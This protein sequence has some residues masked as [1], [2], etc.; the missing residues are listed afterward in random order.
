MK[1]T[2][3]PY[4]PQYTTTPPITTTTPPSSPSQ[5]NQSQPPGLNPYFEELGITTD[6]TLTPAVYNLWQSFASIFLPQS[7][8]LPPS[9]NPVSLLPYAHIVDQLRPFDLILIRTPGFFYT[10]MRRVVEHS[11]DHVAIVL[12]QSCALHI[13]PPFTRIIPVATLLSPIRKPIILRPKLHP[14]LPSQSPSIPSPTI[15]I[16]SKVVSP[17][18]WGP[19]S[20]SM[21]DNGTHNVAISS[22]HIMDIYSKIITHP[23]LLTSLKPP[24]IFSPQVDI[25]S[26]PNYPILKNN[27]IQQFLLF[28]ELFSLLGTHYDSLKMY[29]LWGKLALNRVT[30]QPL[31]K[32]D[33]SG[34]ICTDA[35]INILLHYDFLHLQNVAKNWSLLNSHT[36]YKFNKRSN[37]A[38][39][40][41]KQ[42]ILPHN[43]KYDNL[44]RSTKPHTTAP[45]SPTPSL[46]QSLHPSIHLQI[47]PQPS[48]LHELPLS[49]LEALDY[50][51]ISAWSLNDLLQ[52]THDHIIEPNPQ[53][54]QKFSNIPHL[55]MGM[56]KD[57]QRVGLGFGKNGT[58]LDEQKSG[59]FPQ[60]FSA[61]ENQQLFEGLLTDIDT[62]P[63]QITNPDR[64]LMSTNQGTPSAQQNPSH[65]QTTTSSSLNPTIYQPTSAVPPTHPLDL[66]SVLQHSKNFNTLVNT[67]LLIDSAFEVIKPPEPIPIELI[68][69]FCNQL[70][71]LCANFV[72]RETTDKKNGLGIKSEG[73]GERIELEKSHLRS[74]PQNTPNDEQTKV[75]LNREALLQL[76]NPYFRPIPPKQSQLTPK[77]NPPS[78]ISPSSPS[79]PIEFPNQNLSST[80]EEDITVILADSL[81]YHLLSKLPGMIPFFILQALKRGLESLQRGKKYDIKM[82]VFLTS[83]KIS[84][85]ILAKLESE[86]KLMYNELVLGP[87]VET[88]KILKGKAG[89]V[90]H[91]D[92]Y[93]NQTNEIGESIPANFSLTPLPH[94]GG[95]TL[96]QQQA[97]GTKTTP[98]ENP[99]PHNPNIAQRLQNLFLNLT[100][101]AQN[102]LFKKEN[103]SENNPDGLDPS[104]Q[105]RL[106]EFN[107]EHDPKQAIVI[108]KESD[109]KNLAKNNRI[110]QFPTWMEAILPL[111]LVV[112]IKELVNI[113]ISPLDG[114]KAHK[115]SQGGIKGS[116]NTNPHPF[117]SIKYLSSIPAPFLLYIWSLLKP[118]VRFYLLLTILSKFLPYLIY[119]LTATMLMTIASLPT[120]TISWLSSRA[121]GVTPPPNIIDVNFLALHPEHGQNILHKNSTSLLSKLSILKPSRISPQSK[122]AIIFRPNL[123]GNFKTRFITFVSAV[124][125]ASVLRYV[126]NSR[127][128]HQA[129]Q[130]KVSGDNTQTHKKSFLSKALALQEGS[131]ERLQPRVINRVFGPFGD[132]NGVIK[133]RLPQQRTI[134]P[135]QVDETELLS[136]TPSRIIQQIQGHGGGDGG[137]I[138]AQ[139]KDFEGVGEGAPEQGRGVGITPTLTV[140]VIAQ[141]LMNGYY[142]WISPSK[143][144]DNSNQVDSSDP[145]S[146]ETNGSQSYK[147]PFLR[148]FSQTDHSLLW[149][150]DV[151][152]AT[153][154]VATDTLGLRTLSKQIGQSRSLKEVKKQ[155]GYVKD[156]LSG[157]SK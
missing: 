7:L 12:T 10:N 109:S 156:Q 126:W 30:N 152:K 50:H 157:N 6:S 96:L 147:Y 115:E 112:Q 57:N 3:Y 5:P 85:P 93:H 82:E 128:L 113:F 41:S 53:A 148:F 11:Y 101:F 144:N 110:T 129:I 132:P 77:N 133:D 52:L 40:L 55:G 62:N 118:I 83:P 38:I 145:Q 66:S 71:L 32:I 58:K 81:Y 21:S 106:D 138:G 86:V 78:Q 127:Y 19:H 46:P 25:I 123:I 121:I 47:T 139:K 102:K 56:S 151:F 107:I 103:V 74:T 141:T 140:S 54:L 64:S 69:S 137:V 45:K 84:H 153:A 134:K 111:D 16:G 44:S 122:K 65:T 92:E 61:P 51:R 146:F 143:Q 70:T 99:Q 94:S 33:S 43:L 42:V 89:H 24:S 130:S 8:A 22:Q 26:N 98:N 150:N 31:T 95:K 142:R 72:L 23:T 4:H 155:I 48:I 125:V 135:G 60:Q 120:N 154:Y 104:I 27:D 73:M 108:G 34:I 75:K 1:D 79:N 119:R 37:D 35:I 49:H 63:I 114:Y 87:Y 131:R 80:E 14:I 68:Y 116:L 15:S 20:S 9:L 100:N 117:P 18:Y 90:G 76:I 136:L 67:P 149:L 59:V 36:K 124:V 97:E 2:L 39:S 28:C 105:S 88:Q 29:T 17:Q 13:S 91:H